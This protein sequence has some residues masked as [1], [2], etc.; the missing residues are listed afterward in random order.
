[1]VVA[2]QPT[3]RSSEGDRRDASMLTEKPVRVAVVIPCYRVAAHIGA[4]VSA[5]GP[6]AHAIYIVDDSC[7]EGSGKVVQHELA[8]PR[9]QVMF[10]DRNQGVGGATMTGMREALA[11]GADILVKIDGDG[12]MDPRLL[13]RFINSIRSGEAD[14]AKGNRF[15]DPAGLAA[16]PLTRLVGNAVLSFLAKLSTGYWRSFDPTNGYIAIHAKVAELL[17]WD[18]IDKRYFFESDLLF[19]LN[20]LQAKVV[21]IPMPAVYGS[22]RS[23]L[24]PWREI[25]PFMLGHTRNFGK[26]VVYNYFLRNFSIASVELVLGLLLLMFGTVY[27]VVNWSPGGVPATAGTVM[28]AGLPVIVGFQLVLAFINYDIQVTPTAALHPRL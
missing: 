28:L 20:I 10:H 5:I 19:R 3:I 15:F 4:L 27:G 17:P 8:D 13:P 25:L 22:E 2:P 12:Q 18:R 23:N 24:R 6:E 26:R 21:D 16:M 11:D 9:V 7:P 14:F 1:M